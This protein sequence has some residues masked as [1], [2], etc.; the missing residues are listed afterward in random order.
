MKCFFLLLSCFIVFQNEGNCQ[1]QNYKRP[2]ALGISFSLVDFATPERIRSSS[3]VSVINNKR[4]AKVNEMSPGI[5]ITYFKGLLNHID[6]A[7]TLMGA[8]TTLSPNGN[9]SDQFLLEGDASVN[10][11]MF[12]D[13][14]FFTPYLSAGV[15][16]NSFNKK[17]GA[18]VPLGGGL[19]F[20]IFNEAAI[21]ITTQYRVPV[22]NETGGY[23][24]VHGIGFAGIIG[25]KREDA[26][27]A[28]QLP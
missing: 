4:A 3:L 21:Y 26:T 5:G 25:K 6:F 2:P 15:G 8:F 20:N 11:K 1:T 16:F 19:K 22:T 14:F 18:F 28:V 9:T 17:K 12:S 10:L 13:Q 23:H 24:L 7:A 27:P